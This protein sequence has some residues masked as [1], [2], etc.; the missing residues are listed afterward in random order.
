M[1]STNELFSHASRSGTRELLLNGQPKKIEF[2]PVP[3]FI[4]A[5]M[6]LI[7]VA[8]EALAQT[9]QK[10]FSQSFQSGCCLN[11]KFPR[12]KHVSQS[13][14]PPTRLQRALNCATNNKFI[15]GTRQLAEDLGDRTSLHI[16][17]Y[18][19]TYM[20]EQ[21][22]PAL[23]IGIYS[24]DGKSG[25]L[26]DVYWDSSK[27]FIDNLPTMLR[28]PMQWSVGEINGGLWSYTRLWYLAQEIGSRRRLKIPVA[29]IGHAKPQGCFVF[30]EDQTNWKPQTEKF[31]NQPVGRSRT[32]K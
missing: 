1:M 28:L 9:P 2:G 7:N 27:Y 11:R 29:A 30:I 10:P 24:I 20:P 23:T 14:V 6:L 31:V 12:P 22:G 15:G 8:P 32:S 5:A 25:V 18:Y 17:Y 13:T 26:F 4:F 21:E 19:G 16:A 3:R